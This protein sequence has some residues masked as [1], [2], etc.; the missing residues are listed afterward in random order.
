MQMNKD[1]HKDGFKKQGWNFINTIF[2]HVKQLSGPGSGLQNYNLGQIFPN[3]SFT[4]SSHLK[5]P[6]NPFPKKRRRI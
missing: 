6:L 5:A 4:M 3:L 1:S 2:S